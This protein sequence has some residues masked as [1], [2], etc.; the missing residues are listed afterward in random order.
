M[1]FLAEVIPPVCWIYFI[2]NTLDLFSTGVNEGELE[3]PCMTGLII[4]IIVIVIIII[5]I[6]TKK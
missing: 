4:I 6:K 3:L 1:S 2:Y 5:I